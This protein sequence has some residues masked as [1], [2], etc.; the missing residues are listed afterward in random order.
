MVEPRKPRETK[1]ILKRASPDELR[2][3]DRLLSERF[4]QD[5]S[6]ELTTEQ[7]AVDARRQQRIAEL[8]LRIFGDR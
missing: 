2:E 7:R 8:A 5:P 1:E 3:Y 4:E 6:L